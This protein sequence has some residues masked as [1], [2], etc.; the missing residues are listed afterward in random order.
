M[1]PSP[2]LGRGEAFYLLIIHQRGDHK[3]RSVW[4]RFRGRGCCALQPKERGWEYLLFCCTLNEDYIES[5]EEPN[6]HPF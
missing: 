1:G 3:E 6:V 4:R 2:S 5:L